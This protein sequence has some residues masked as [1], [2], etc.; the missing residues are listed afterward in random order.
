MGRVERTFVMKVEQFK[1]WLRE[2]TREKPRHLKLVKSGEYKNFAFRDGH[3]PDA[4]TWT[5]MILITKSVGGHRSIGLVGVIWNVCTLI[6]KKQT[7]EWHHHTLCLTRLQT[8]EGD[9]H[10]NH[11]GKYGTSIC[12]NIP[13]TTFQVFIDMQ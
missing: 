7:K 1:A 12:R 2:A 11:G 13:Q 4:L 5:T 8:G 10:I 3:I 6:H 9:R